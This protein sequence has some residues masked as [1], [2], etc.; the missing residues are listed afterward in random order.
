MSEK[1]EVLT[2]DESIMRHLLN[3]FSEKVSRNILPVCKLAIEYCNNGDFDS[4]LE[5]PVGVQTL[6]PNTLEYQN[7]AFS[8]DI[9]HWAQLYAFLNMEKMEQY[10]E[11]KRNR[12]RQEAKGESTESE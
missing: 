2:L 1:V 4:R 7:T 8:G 5:L 11:E 6:N 3:H 9:I 12:L 10:A